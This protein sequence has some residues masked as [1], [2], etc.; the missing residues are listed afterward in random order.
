[1]G[2]DLRW[3]NLSTVQLNWIYFE[4][5]FYPTTSNFIVLHKISTRM[6]CVDQV[7]SP[8][9]FVLQT[10][11]SVKYT[12]PFD[13]S[14]NQIFL[15]VFLWKSVAWPGR[16]LLRACSHGVGDLRSVRCK[17]ACLYNL[18]YGHLIYYVNVIKLKWDIREPKQPESWRPGRQKW[19]PE[20]DIFSLTVLWLDKFVQ[21]E[22]KQ[23]H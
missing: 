8:E 5:G 12:L 7:S 11:V 17:P 23:R 16:R 14:L 1:M 3:C 4:A 22:L 20:V 21:R 18:F 19:Q 10:K 9:G 2:C 13:L 6:T 15:S